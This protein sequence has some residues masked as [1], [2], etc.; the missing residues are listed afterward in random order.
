MNHCLR[1]RGYF[2]FL[3]IFMSLNKRSADYGID[4]NASR[5]NA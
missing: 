4:F 1:P 3:C 2:T 5:G